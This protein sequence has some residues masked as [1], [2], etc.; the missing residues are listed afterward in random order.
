MTIIL[1]VFLFLLIVTGYTS[2][3]YRPSN[4]ARPIVT[5]KYLVF[6]LDERRLSKFLEEKKGIQGFSIKEFQYDEE[7][8]RVKIDN[9]SWNYI[10]GMRT[11]MK[12]QP[13]T[14]RV[15]IKAMLHCEFDRG[16]CELI[17]E[18]GKDYSWTTA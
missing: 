11:F 3:P 13:T 6:E 14:D 15:A 12:S 5:T 17:F 9:D 10:S 1:I 4:K 8:K 16:K 7:N 18:A 2:G